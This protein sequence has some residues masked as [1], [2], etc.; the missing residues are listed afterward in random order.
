MVVDLDETGAKRTVEAIEKGGGRRVALTRD[1]TTAAANQAMVERAMTLWAGSTSSS[2]TRACRSEDRRRGRGRRA[3]RQD[4]GVN[5]KGVFLG[6]KYALPVMKKARRACSWSRRRRGD[7]AASGRSGL[8]DVEG[9]RRSPSRRAS[10]SRRRRTACAWWRW[11]G[12]DLHADARHVHEQ[13]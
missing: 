9:R 2:P 3:L 11:P 8:R 1:V 10:R 5:V 4:H 13:A 12:R 7:P 6:A